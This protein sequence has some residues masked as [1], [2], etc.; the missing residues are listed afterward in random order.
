M[1]WP[2]K[3]DAERRVAEARRAAATKEVSDAAR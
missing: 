2:V 1:L 3:A